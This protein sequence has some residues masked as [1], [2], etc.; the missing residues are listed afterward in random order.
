MCLV[1]LCTVGMSDVFGR[2]TVGMS[3]VFG[4][5]H[6]MGRANRAGGAQL[7]A[8]RPA[9]WRSMLK[10]VLLLATSHG[11]CTGLDKKA[12]LLQRCGSTVWVWACLCPKA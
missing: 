1:Q 7:G 3:D 9:G 5:A 8:G 10:A 11:S 12:L 4:P 6:R 2:C